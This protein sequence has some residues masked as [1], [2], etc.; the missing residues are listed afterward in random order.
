MLN[1][2]EFITEALKGNGVENDAHDVWVVVNGE[3]YTVSI[4]EVLDHEETEPFEASDYLENYKEADAWD[5]L[6]EQ[7]VGA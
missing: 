4:D 1:K 2:E 7:Y 3:Q 5:D 6:Y